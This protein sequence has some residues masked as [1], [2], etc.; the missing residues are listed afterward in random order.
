VASARQDDIK[1]CLCPF[2]RQRRRESQ[3]KDGTL[4]P[5]GT[6][7]KLSSGG[8]RLAVDGRIAVEEKPQEYEAIYA[9]FD[10]LLNEGKSHIDAAP[11]LLV[12]DAFLI[13]KRKEVEA[14]VE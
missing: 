14:F 12:A 7:L 1:R 6:K 13:G 9:H 2:V 8:A 10:R 11:F 3:T 5:E 4:P